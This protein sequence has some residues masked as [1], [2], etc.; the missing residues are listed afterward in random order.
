MAP[1]DPE[2]AK[3]WSATES[4][5]IIHLDSDDNISLSS[6]FLDGDVDGNREEDAADK[7]DNGDLDF[8]PFRDLRRP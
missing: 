2:Y 5:V 1:V 8:T 3:W 7:A 6:S 4:G